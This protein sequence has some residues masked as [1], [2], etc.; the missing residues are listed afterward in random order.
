M[1]GV[2]R[3]VSLDLDYGCHHGRYRFPVKNAPTVILGS[4]GS[5][6]STLVDALVRTIYGFNRRESDARR[7]QEHRR[8]WKGGRFRARVTLEDAEGRLSIERDFESNQVVVRRL[9]PDEEIFRGEANPAAPSS[10]DQQAY[11]KLL[12][13]LFGLTE[14]DD[15]ER[16]ACIQQGHLLGTELA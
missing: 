12:H 15:Y 4:N 8:P 6:K 1:S 2:V 7:A 5:G 3:F 13:K 14:L 11:R 9:A 10:S 16:T